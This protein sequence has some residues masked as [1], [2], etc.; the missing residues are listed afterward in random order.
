MKETHHTTTHQ[1]VRKKNRGGIPDRFILIALSLV[2]FC[3]F[4]F[5]PGSSAA[6][7]PLPMRQSPETAIGA[8]APLF[9]NTTSPRLSGLAGPMVSGYQPDLRP[10]S[11]VIDR[12]SIDD[13]GPRHTLD[14]HSA[15]ITSLAISPDSTVVATGAA[16]G[17]IRL[18]SVGSG[19]P[20][21]TIN[22]HPFAVNDLAF[23]PE[24]DELVSASMER[25][26]KI[27]D[28]RTGELNRTIEARLLDRV[29]ELRFTPD[30]KYLAVAGHKCL[31]V[32]RDFESGILYK[33]Y[34]QRNCLSRE[35]G[36]VDSWGIDFTVDGGEI[37]LGSGQPACNCGSIQRWEL[38]VIASNNLVYG[39]RIPVN[40]I[41]LSPDGENLAISMIG[42][43]FIRVIAFD[44][45]YPFRDLSGHLFRVNR[46]QYSPDGKLLASASNDQRIGL[47]DPSTGEL[48]RLIH[49]HTDAVSEV[50]FCPDGT[51]LVSASKDGGAIVWGLPTQ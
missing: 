47:W 33:T 20:Q 43:D 41:D 1:I 13:L 11:A 28:I 35:Y 31:V 25:T 19:E 24:G 12:E 44:G 23:S 14:G 50:Q 29:L 6:G 49:E 22:A 17:E 42:S 37:I 15:A 46:I 9:L 18:W 5:L 48:L 21:L 3:V 36:S 40:D 26:V 4:A 39:Y 51:C 8:S 34:H 10:A 32:L 45:I 2:S 38:D 16:D 7:R 30:G 27:W